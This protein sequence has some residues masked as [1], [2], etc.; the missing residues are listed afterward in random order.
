VLH[1]TFMTQA[2]DSQFRVFCIWKQIM[3]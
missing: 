1:T 3:F 2:V